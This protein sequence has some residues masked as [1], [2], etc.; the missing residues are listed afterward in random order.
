ML[1][2]PPPKRLNLSRFYYEN[3]EHHR[4]TD[5]QG[6]AYFLSEDIRLFDAAFFR[7]NP[8]EAE[9]IDPQQW[10][11]LKTVY[12]A[13]EAAGYPLEAVSSTRTSVYVGVINADYT[14]I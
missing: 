4:S 5:V 13:L 3:R 1:T 14:D 9:G 8:K 6:R 11:L 2:N 7:I 12:E 10:I